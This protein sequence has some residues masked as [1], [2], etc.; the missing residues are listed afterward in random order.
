[1]FGLPDQ[2][3]TLYV[4]IVMSSHLVLLVSVVSKL[5]LWHG[6]ITLDQEFVS[7]SKSKKN[8]LPF[9][10]KSN[11]WPFSLTAYLCV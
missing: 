8:L 4:E 7:R 2:L 6:R 3:F 9:A 10:I 1:M 5:L 11:V